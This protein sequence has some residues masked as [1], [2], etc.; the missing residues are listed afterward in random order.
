M[1]RVKHILLSEAGCEVCGELYDQ[2]RAELGY[3]TCVTCG[4]RQARQRKH[5]VVPLHKSNY[6]VP[7]NADELRGINNKGGFFR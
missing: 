3:T 4:E 6:M 1:G 7:A 5:T 2:R